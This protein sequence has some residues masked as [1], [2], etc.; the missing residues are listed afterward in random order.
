M[1]LTYA[2]WQAQLANLMATTTTDP[3]FVVMLP[4][5]IDYAEQRG[6]RDLDLQY[7]I[8]TDSTGALTISNRNFTLP[9]NTAAGF[10]GSTF[11]V[12]NNVNLITPA[13]TP[14]STGSR[15][16]LT[17]VSQA[18]IDA[19][20]PSSASNTGQPSVYC[21]PNSTQL[22]VGPSPDGAYVL[23]VIGTQ[24]PQPLSATNTSTILTTYVP[25]LFM[26]ASMIYASGY[27]R[28]FGAQ[29]DDPRMAASWE[30]QYMNLLKS[31]Q[32][33]QFRARFESA[34]YSSQTPSPV[35]APRT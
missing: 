33:E 17:P 27:M 34:G 28:N 14:A 25:D 21:R 12:V 30:G 5:A 24:R 20:W 11:I 3:N 13:G 8:V 1:S 22:T 35:A 18:V 7:T 23:E 31:A 2:T 32:V 19:S 10:V 29:S 9:V 4:G 16:P 6:Y 15:T 26:A